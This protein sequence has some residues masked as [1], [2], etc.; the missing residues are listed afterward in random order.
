MRS[1]DP[2][3]LEGELEGGGVAPGTRTVR[4]MHRAR[5]RARARGCEVHGGTNLAPECL[6]M[7]GIARLP[8]PAVALPC[9]LGSVACLMHVRVRRYSKTLARAQSTAAR[10][11][12]PSFSP[13][14]LFSRERHS[15]L[16]LSLSFLLFP[17]LTFSPSALF[18]LLVVGGALHAPRFE[19]LFA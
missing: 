10:E 19:P 11:E 8:S 6:R 9:P 5:A 7:D 14:P 12:V 17:P 3:R 2:R 13:P 15:T 18:Q 1:I 4:I 16:S